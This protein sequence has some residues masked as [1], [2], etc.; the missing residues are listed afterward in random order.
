MKKSAVLITLMILTCAAVFAADT[1]IEEI[2]ARVNSSIITRADLQRSREQTMQELKERFG[3]TTQAQS[4]ATNR[5]KD[6][7][8]DLIDQQLLVQKATDLGITGDTELIKRLDEIRKSMN[9]DSMD[10][11]EKSAQQQGISYEDFKQNLKNQILTQQVIQREVGSHL[12]VT[13]EETKKY[14]EEHQ[15]ELEQPETVRLSEILCSPQKPNMDQNAAADTN[16]V[17]EAQTKAEVALAAIKKGETFDAV[18]KK[19][20]DGPTAGQGGDLGEFK[21]GMLSKELE[22]KTFAMKPGDVTDIIR[23][24]Q[25]FV[26]L[27]VTEHRMAG[28]PPLKTIEPQ[29]QQALY[30]EKLQP[31]L[32]E[33]LTKLREQAYIDIRPGFVDTG[34]SPNQTKPIV[35]SAEVPGAKTKPKKK[36]KL[37]IL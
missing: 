21:R 18:A 19:W 31:A 4:E 30:Y 14:Y 25:G 10:A 3:N 15:K 7:L 8:R 11:L 27:K 33:Y 1:V 5:E 35:T 16:T 23:T 24:K 29:I 12:M 17:D 9:L 6:A 32:R 37:G 22:D 34:A 26:I 28:L 13:E 36:K 2:I 20:S